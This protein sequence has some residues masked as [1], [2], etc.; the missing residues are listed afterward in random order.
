MQA[1][2]GPDS[3]PAKEETEA[4]LEA[5]NGGMQQDSSME[6]GQ[7]VDSAQDQEPRS[8]DGHT[9]MCLSRNSLFLLN[10]P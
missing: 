3:D 6:E 10:E 8:A 1:E 9:G 7:E 2:A 4:S 5:I